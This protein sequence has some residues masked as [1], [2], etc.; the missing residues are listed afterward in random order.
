MPLSPAIS[1]DRN[2]LVV[3]ELGSSSLSSAPLIHIL[4][5]FFCVIDLKITRGS[6]GADQNM[7]MRSDLNL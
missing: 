5:H 6:D 3:I 2:M 1:P 7:E 4:Q